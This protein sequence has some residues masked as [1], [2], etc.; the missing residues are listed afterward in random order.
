MRRQTSC[1]FFQNST[2]ND[3]LRSL[4]DHVH[5]T[6]KKRDTRTRFPDFPPGCPSTFSLTSVLRTEGKQK[7][8]FQGLV[9]SKTR[10]TL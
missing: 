6:A 7:V 5:V 9:S 10:V 8:S 4:I 1:T 2:W 3:R